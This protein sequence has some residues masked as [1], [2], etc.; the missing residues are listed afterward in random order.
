ML[1]LT[2]GGGDDVVGIDGLCA[3]MR[4][5]QKRQRLDSLQEKRIGW[6]NVECFM[7]FRQVGSNSQQIEVEL[8]L[9][10]W[11]GG[12]EEA[13]SQCPTRFIDSKCSFI[14]TT[15]L[16]VITYHGSWHKALFARSI[17]AFDCYAVLS[18][19]CIILRPYILLEQHYVSLFIPYS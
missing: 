8:I 15:P 10:C 12:G 19:K 18:W 13:H 4:G 5:S 6:L 16:Q 1:L 2:A 17:H 11:W 9:C 3:L 14:G 7:P